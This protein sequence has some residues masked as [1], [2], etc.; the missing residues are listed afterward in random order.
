M[1][2]QSNKNPKI[3]QL[4]KY[5]THYSKMD[6][7]NNNNNNN[8]QEK[9][10]QLISNGINTKVDVYSRKNDDIKKQSMQ[11]DNNKSNLEKI[12]NI[13][14]IFKDLDLR[15]INDFMLLKNP[16]TKHLKTKKRNKNKNKN[17]NTTNNKRKNKNKNTTYNKR[18]NK[19]KNKRNIKNKTKKQKKK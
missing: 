13:E 7:N 2:F 8:I 1:I 19:N 5:I 4:H 16:T 17:K 14:P 9:S 6:N 12:L 18:K 3:K 11:F 15:L 10:L